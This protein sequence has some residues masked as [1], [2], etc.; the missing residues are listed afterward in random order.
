MTSF[1]PKFNEPP[2]LVL[3]DRVPTDYGFTSPPVAEDDSWL[4]RFTE[5][6]V[7]DLFCLP[8]VSLGMVMRIVVGNKNSTFEEPTGDIPPNAAAV[9]ND[10]ALNPANIVSE[11]AVAWADL[12]LP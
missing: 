2:F 10:D 9:L 6:G 3:P 12:T 8:H 11:G 5:K 4:Y 7:Y 1:D